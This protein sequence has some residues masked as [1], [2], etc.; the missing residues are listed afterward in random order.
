MQ[1]LPYAQD[2]AILAAKNGS[3]GLSKSWAVAWTVNG[4][5]SLTSVQLCEQVNM[6]HSLAS[7]VQTVSWAV[8]WS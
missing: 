7:L 6:H 3:D 1:M 5:D 4:K 2:G 8:V